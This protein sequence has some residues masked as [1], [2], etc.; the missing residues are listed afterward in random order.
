M[1]RRKMSVPA[2]HELPE[3]LPHMLL[4]LTP[5]DVAA[6][7]LV[8]DAIVDRLIP[9][10]LAHHKC[11]RGCAIYD[12]KMAIRFADMAKDLNELQDGYEEVIAQYHEA[13]GEF[14]LDALRA[15]FMRAAAEDRDEFP[16]MEMG[17]ADLGALLDT[18]AGF[19]AA[20]GGVGDKKKT[21]KGFNA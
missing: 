5:E 8:R 16:E 1:A 3:R 18:V 14:D 12:P 4:A 11:G 7:R 15:K 17:E 21:K 10:M 2:K 20:V 9:H 6:M 13:T 19:V